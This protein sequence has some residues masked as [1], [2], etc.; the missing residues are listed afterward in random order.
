LQ[1]QS[2]SASGATAAVEAT[3]SSGNVQVLGN[4][5]N[6]G[7]AP[8]AQRSAAISAAN[9]LMLRELSGAASGSAPDEH[10]ATD[11]ATSSSGERDNNVQ[12][13]GIAGNGAAPATQASAATSAATLQALRELSKNSFGDVASS[14]ALDEHGLHGATSGSALTARN[15]GDAAAGSASKACRGGDILEHQQQVT[16]GVASGGNGGSASDAPSK[17]SQLRLTP[18]ALT[19]LLELH[20][21]ELELLQPL[22]TNTCRELV[23]ELKAATRLAHEGHTLTD[24][25]ALAALEV[26]RHLPRSSGWPTV[27]QA[28]TSG[29]CTA[30][31][32]LQMSQHDGQWT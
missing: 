31:T 20:N 19:V 9:L 10:G 29:L 23:R 6:G 30:L 14:S 32:Q 4:I 3:A 26:A 17:A 28:A 13:L 11:A 5:A 18:A 8:A 21:G 7:A 16:L 15:F 25:V 2:S 24:A 1:A 22:E 12:V 27:E